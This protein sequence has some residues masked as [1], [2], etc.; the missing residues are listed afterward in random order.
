M[1]DDSLQGRWDAGWPL[2]LIHCGCSLPPCAGRGLGVKILWLVVLAW[3]LWLHHAHLLT[4]RRSG[5]C[6]IRRRS[7]LV[8]LAIRIVVHSRLNMRNLC[9]ILIHLHVSECRILSS[10]GLLRGDHLLLLLLPLSTE[11]L[12]ALL[13]LYAGCWG[14]AGA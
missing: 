2:L 6:R 9:S 11:T 14:P 10:L 13:L 8:V 1:T 12:V 4:I 5:L 7:P 3:L